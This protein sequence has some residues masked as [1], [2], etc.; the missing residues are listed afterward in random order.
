MVYCILSTMREYLIVLGRE[1]ALSVAEL[2]AVARRFGLPLQLRLV[3]K[4]VARASGEITEPML[5]ALAGIIKV[6][7]VLGEVGHNKAELASYLFDHLPASGRCEFGLSWYGDK[8][9]RW[10]ASVGLELKNRLKADERHVRFV[11]SR[12]PALSSVVVRKNKLLPPQGYEFILWPD[13]DKVV[14]G[15]TVWVQDFAAWSERDYGRPERDARVGMLPP[16]LARLM[17]N[18][19]EAP[20]GAGILDPFCGSGT[21][22]QE[23]AILGYRHLVGVDVDSQGVERTRAN[24]SWLRQRQ[25]QLPAPALMV[26]DI[27][28]LPAVLN[29]STFEAVVTEPYLGPPLRGREGE[30][31]LVQIHKELTEFYRYALKVL[32]NVVKLGG[33]IVMVWPVL[34][35]GQNS[36]V[37]PLINEVKSLGLEVVDML[38]KQTPPEWRHERKT[39]W[40]SRP[41]ARVIREIVVLGRL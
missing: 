4:S 13:E 41:D 20:A 39:L 27:N 28:K 15:R 38:P 11:T 36:V 1:P 29:H 8:P 3:S 9:P 23:A 34:K 14:V 10:L 5:L 26:A 32:A 24:F 37:L 12:T 6:A 35:V 16:K 18:L 21:V 40:Y 17:I 30:R 2:T 22:L 33:R 7:E 25:P 31:R 19:A